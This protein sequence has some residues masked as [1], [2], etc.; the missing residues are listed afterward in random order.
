[1]RGSAALNAGYL[2]IAR[3]AAKRVLARDGTS[4]ADRVR[5]LLDSEGTELPGSGWWG[6]LFVADPDYRWAVAG[7]V[8]TK[9]KGSRSSEIKTWRE[10]SV[11]ARA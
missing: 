6:S 2:R 7:H 3:D 9:R 11:I 4:D 10:L 1:M 8:N 5:L